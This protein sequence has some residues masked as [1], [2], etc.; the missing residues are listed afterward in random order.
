MNFIYLLVYFLCVSNSFLSAGR[1]SCFRP[2]CWV[3][4]LSGG[5]LHLAAANCGETPYAKTHINLFLN[6][7]VIPIT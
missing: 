6:K 5:L 4:L 3:A 2:K 7:N 1:K